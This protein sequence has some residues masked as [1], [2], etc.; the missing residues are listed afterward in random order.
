MAGTHAYT[1]LGR[2]EHF[3]GP[4]F[5]VVTDEVE[6]PGGVVARRD[7]L[8]H[9]GAVGVVPLDEADRVVLVRQYRHPIGRPLW[10]L[11]AGLVD[12]AGESL[13]EVAARE[14]AEEADL[15]ADRWDLLLDLHP[16]PGCSNERIRIFLGRQL[17]PAPHPHQREHEEAELVVARFPLAEAVAM[18]FR[19]EI[20]NGACVTGLLATAHARARDWAP[21]RPVDAADP[22]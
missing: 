12:V 3:A 5:S 21:L 1:V 16:S 6:M 15:V 18:I 17:R 10:E 22:A 7:Y 19:G 20:T 14:L 8:R 11:P 9:I 2:T 13:P 4:M